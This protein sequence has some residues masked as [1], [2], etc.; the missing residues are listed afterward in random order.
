MLFVV[1]VMGGGM[2]PNTGVR[3]HKVIITQNRF[4]G[5]DS[6]ANM[7]MTASVQWTRCPY[8]FPEMIEPCECFADNHYKG[9]VQISD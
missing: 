5:D 4:S 2:T 7:E 9:L 1:S 8:P 3:K 6:D